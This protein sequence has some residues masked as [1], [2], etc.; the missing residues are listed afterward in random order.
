MLAVV[1]TIIIVPGL[2]SCQQN[3]TA[4]PAPAET[5]GKPA[6]PPALVQKPQPSPFI[7]SATIQDIMTS[8][9]DPSADYL[10]D[11]VAIIGTKDGIEER[12]PRTDEEW[13]EV[14]HRAITLMEAANLLAME[15]RRVVGE[16]KHL[17]DEG[18]EGNLTAM[19]IQKLID[20]DHAS[21]AALA[22]ALNSTA[23]QALQAIEQRDVDAFLEAGGII[24]TSC[25]GCHTVYWYP[26]QVIPQ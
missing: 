6:V 19:E 23:G 22:R 9:V 16:G 13:L 3:E 14:R 26:N 24:D 5:A 12:Q 25:E 11:S 1:L 18:L 17:E 21:F 2:V 7:L 8:I 15:G 4:I 20:A 10:W